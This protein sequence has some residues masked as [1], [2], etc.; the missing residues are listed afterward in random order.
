MKFWN[1]LLLL[2]FLSTGMIGLLMVIKINYKLE[3]SFYE[4]MVGYH[5]GFGIG[6][7]LIGFF[8]LWWHLSYYRHSIWLTG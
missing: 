3:L 6:M 5:V 4:Q 8:H 1:A 7:V 2:T